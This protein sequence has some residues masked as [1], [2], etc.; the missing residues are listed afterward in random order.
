MTTHY[1]TAPLRRRPVLGTM[2]EARPLSALTQKTHR[3]MRA[4]GA[5]DQPRGL[6]GWMDPIINEMSS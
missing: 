6:R 4:C 2:G 1:S 5:L 3:K